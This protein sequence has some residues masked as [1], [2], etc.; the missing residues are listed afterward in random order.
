M[1]AALGTFLA[2]I[3][4]LSPQICFLGLAM[5]LSVPAVAWLKQSA[6]LLL[7]AAVALIGL[8]VA[9][10]PRGNKSYNV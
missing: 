3:N 10:W 9:F 5:A 1:L 4:L 6:L 7:L 8:Y 2:G